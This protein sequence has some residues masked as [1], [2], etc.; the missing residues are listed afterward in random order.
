[1]FGNGL[2]VR[3]D[4]GTIYEPDCLIR[5]GSPLDGAALEISDPVVVVEVVSPSS[6]LR[7]SVDK[8]A[9]YFRVA[10]VRHYLIVSTDSRGV[11]LHSRRDDGGI[12][13]AILS[14]GKPRLDPPG[15]SVEIASFFPA[16]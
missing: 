1:M 5:C 12:E 7:D 15:V 4:A 11:I 14:G 16:R 6:R 2:G 10:S 8:L 9:G 13:T 3:V